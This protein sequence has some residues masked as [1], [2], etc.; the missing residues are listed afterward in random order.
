MSEAKGEDF[1]SRMENPRFWEEL[2]ETFETAIDLLQ[3]IA[4]AQGIDVAVPGTEAVQDEER[5][6]DD[7]ARS[8][9]LVQ[10]AAEYAQSVD[11]WF[12][13]AKVAIREWGLA[14]TQVAE[15]KGLTPDVEAEA[16][17]LQ[18][19]IES[20]A[21]ARYRIS[22]KLIRAL[23]CR[24][25]GESE[26]LSPMPGAAEKA[27]AEAYILIEDSIRHWMRLREII[28]SEEDA[29]LH[30]LVNLGRLRDGMVREFDGAF[31]SAD[32]LASEG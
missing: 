21:D 25:R 24:L 12:R 7:E 14:A 13:Q 27:A 1:A 29:I 28:P 16:D 26:I 32:P 22:V 18:D 31:T 3:E 30:L 17:D 6:L 15:E 20:L 2:Q 8:H 4:E 10:G 19:A 11:V 5:R 23:R 9:E